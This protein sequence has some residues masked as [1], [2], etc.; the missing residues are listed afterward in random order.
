MKGANAAASSSADGAASAASVL[1]KAA[2][3]AMAWKASMRGHAART[4]SMKGWKAKAKSD[5]VME[6]AVE[7]CG[8]AVDEQGRPDV[9]ALGRVPA[10]MR[11]AAGILVRSSKAFARS[12]KLYRRAGAGL[13]RA[14]RAYRLAGDSM[15]AAEVRRRAAGSYEYARTAA[16]NEASA[17]RGAGSFVR[18]ADDLEAGMAKCSS[19]GGGRMG[20]DPDIL[21][22]IRAEMREAGRKARMESDAMVGRMKE[23]VRSAEELRGVAAEAAKRSAVDAARAVSEYVDGGGPDVKKAEAAWRKAMAAA[24]RTYADE[25]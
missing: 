25:G 5:G 16:N 8:R 7:E 20:G 21:S 3:D 15:L 18:D 10:T 14:S 23:V 22:S 6:R 1:W 12:S 2:A 13:K 9:E 4:E 17:R 24:T 19:G 11:E